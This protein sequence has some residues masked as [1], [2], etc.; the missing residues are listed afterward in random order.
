M[1]TEGS[2][3][4]QLL[5]LAPTIACCQQ[6]QAVELDCSEP[7]TEV[8]LP[9]LAGL[10]ALREFELWHHIRQACS[11]RAQDSA[12][13]QCAR[14]R[15]SV[16][17]FSQLALFTQ[18][19][20]LRFRTGGTDLSADSGLWG[21]IQ[22]LSQLQS[23]AIIDAEAPSRPDGDRKHAAGAAMGA[24]LA[25][26]TRLTRLDLTIQGLAAAAPHLATLPRLSE[27]RIDAAVLFSISGPLQ[28]QLTTLTRV[29]ISVGGAPDNYKAHRTLL[30]LTRHCRLAALHVSM[31]WHW[32]RYLD[33]VPLCRQVAALSGLQRLDF[34]CLP[35][36]QYP[37]TVCAEELAQLTAL[38]YLRLHDC[39]VHHQFMLEFGT[40]VKTLPSRVALDLGRNRGLLRV[41]GLRATKGLEAMLAALPQLT[42]LHLADCELVSTELERLAPLLLYVPGLQHLDLANPSWNHMHLDDGHAVALG[43]RLGALTRLTTLDLQISVDAAGLHAL[44][45][46]LARLVHLKPREWAEQGEASGSERACQG[47][48]GDP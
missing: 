30:D 15:A 18:L 1:C 2:I 32:H 29:C 44:G 11:T 24:A 9:H 10:T 43:S 36:R 37:P 46:H 23:L 17:L 14:Q 4:E 16:A 41:G 3:A 12:A 8:L 33:V 26:L 21:S 22:A 35:L 45:T 7:V 31:R 5:A 20:R 34:E 13:A 19:T 40:A 28:A 47:A 42:R 27:L 38:T 6:L 25:Q 39:N 48:A